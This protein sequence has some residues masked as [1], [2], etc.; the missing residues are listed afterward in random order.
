MG[1]VT[2]GNNQNNQKQAKAGASGFKK[3]FAHKKG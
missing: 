2:K 1:K 3:K